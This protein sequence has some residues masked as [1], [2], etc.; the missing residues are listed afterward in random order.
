MKA[1][2]WLRALVTH[3]LPAP[4]ILQA[5]NGWICYVEGP[6][7]GHWLDLNLNSAWMLLCHLD[8]GLYHRTPQG[9]LANAN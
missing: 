4:K 7:A 2:M 6:I 1:L 3:L 9:T 8:A 5:E